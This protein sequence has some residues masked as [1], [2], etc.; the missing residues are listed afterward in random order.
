MRRFHS[1]TEIGQLRR[2]IRL[3]WESGAY[4]TILSF[5]LLLL[6]TGVSLG[7][8]YLLKLWVDAVALS[9]GTADPWQ[10]LHKVA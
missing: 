6:Q 9:V 8:L 10:A 1:R 4:W 7:A 3:V 2:T 5:I